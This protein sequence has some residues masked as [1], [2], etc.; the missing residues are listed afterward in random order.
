MSMRTRWLVG[1]VAVL[2]V[3]A[4]LFM[5]APLRWVFADEMAAQGVTDIDGASLSGGRVWLSRDAFS[6]V[7]ELNYRWCPMSGLRS[8]CVV[9]EGELLDADATVFFGRHGMR[10]MDGNIQHLSSAIFGPAASL[11]DLQIQGTVNE[12][13]LSSYDCPLQ[14]VASFEADLRVQRSQVL[15]SALGAHRLV[16][17]NTSRGVDVAIDGEALSGT[18]SLSERGYEAS[19]ELIAEAALG[20]MAR[21][22]MRPLGENRYAWEI[23]GRMPC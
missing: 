22:L 21:T 10:I 12:L 16:S 13:V 14:S 17:K 1:G 8:W 11:V 23:E 6:G 15:G 5:T 20:A 7:I 18:M 9:A 4:V 3:G 2:A 19:G